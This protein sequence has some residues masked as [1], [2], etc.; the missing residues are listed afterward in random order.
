[1]PLYALKDTTGAVV[2]YV[3]AAHVGSREDRRLAKA[4]YA[5]RVEAKPAD[6]PA[7]PDPAAPAHKAPKGDW[8]AYAIDRGMPSYEAHAATKDELIERYGG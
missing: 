5:E 3:R 4:S 1:M 2:E 6:E 8:V 7:G